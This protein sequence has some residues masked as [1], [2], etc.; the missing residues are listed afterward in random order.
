MSY[1]QIT[2]DRTHKQSS[3]KK[4]A[5]LLGIIC[6][7]HYLLPLKTRLTIYHSL[8]TS[9]VDYCFIMWGGPTQT[10]IEKLTRLHNTFLKIIARKEPDQSVICMQQKYKLASVQNLYR[11]N[12]CR[13]IKKELNQKTVL[14]DSANLQPSDR[15]QRINMIPVS[16]TSGQYFDHA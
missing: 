9:S 7:S 14:S 3:G 2:C 15:L 12:I 6:R 16:I 11:Y 10:N 1:F 13:T 4:T 8:F 5:R